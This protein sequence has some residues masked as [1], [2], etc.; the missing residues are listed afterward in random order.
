M[1]GAHLVYQFLAGIFLT[2]V[3]WVQKIGFRRRLSKGLGRKVSDQELLSIS[4]WMKIADKEKS[5]IRTAARTCE[6]ADFAPSLKN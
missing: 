1:E 6:S 3:A 2:V 4:T 5:N